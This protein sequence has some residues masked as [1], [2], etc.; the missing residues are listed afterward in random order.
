MLIN[1]KNC[2][3]IE[4]C[5]DTT[6]S[7]YVQ[8][9]TF[10]VPTQQEVTVSVIQTNILN[11][12]ST[13]STRTLNLT[14]GFVSY[15]ER[16]NIAL[17]VHFNKNLY[18]RIDFLTIYRDLFPTVVFTGPENYSQILH[19]R[20]GHL[21]YYSY[22]CVSR[23]I[24]QYPNYTGYLLTHFD[25][26]PIF[27]NLEKR[28]LSNIWLPEYDLADPSKLHSGQLRHTRRTRNFLNLK[29]LFI[30]QKWLYIT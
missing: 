1:S 13:T 9:K 12:N 18:Q 6:I 29:P 27:H 16:N 22:E 4:L 14:R 25:L 28:N 21:G 30:A 5:C 8:V 19:C 26:L 17:V 2:F 10:S 7:C 11:Q 24:I 23:V 3:P 20:E 15:W